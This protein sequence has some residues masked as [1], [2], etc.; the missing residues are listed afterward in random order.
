MLELMM[1]E[2]GFTHQI[3][4]IGWKRDKPN[5]LAYPYLSLR[6]LSKNEILEFGL[7]DFE[8]N[9]MLSDIRYCTG[10]HDE[11]GIYHKCPF[12]NEARNS[13]GQCI[14]CSK[15]VGFEEAF[16]Y[17]GDINPRMQKHLSKPHLVY[18]AYFQPGIIK[19]GT[20]VESR[21]ILRTIEQDALIATFIAENDGFKIQEIERA[22]SRLGYTEAVK[23]SH[24]L[25]YISIKP[26]KIEAIFKLYSEWQ[27]I[28]SKISSREI[29][30]KFYHFNSFEDFKQKTHSH[31]ENPHIFFPAAERP[32]NL[33]KDNPQLISGKFLGLRGKYLITEQS[34]LL[35][36]LSKSRLVGRYLE[37][38]D[39]PLKIQNT[40][41]P[42]LFD[43]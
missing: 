9:W 35:S 41:Q 17:G 21:N 26:D 42:S 6:D 22:I 31:L 18:L 5:S 4:Y 8:F 23:S 3:H 13:F 30:E 27:S 2:Q 11:E 29:F 36:T 25:K 1:S 15:Q 40:P 20:A 7:Q 37:Y 34:N 38:S 10:Y 16:F 39:Q 43:L 14:Y 28:T 12:N 19:V 24:K 32:I 33:V